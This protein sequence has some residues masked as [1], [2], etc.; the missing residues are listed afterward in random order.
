[1]KSFN[2]LV[3]V[4]LLCLLITL[5]HPLASFAQEEAG[6]P[7]QSGIVVFSQNKCAY[8][9]FQKLNALT[10]SVWAPVL[11]DL[12]EE[13]MIVSWGILTHAWGDEWNWNVYYTVESHAAFL[14]FWQEMV[15]R[16]NESHPDFWKQLYPLCTEHKDN[17]YSIHRSA[18]QE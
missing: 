13:D 1:M 18:T 6:E 2:S 11:D 3:P 14:D 9:N 10:D 7:T 16:I 15:G 4:T 17:I 5:I 8:Q 12:V